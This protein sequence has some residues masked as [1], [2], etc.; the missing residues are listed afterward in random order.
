MRIASMRGMSITLVCALAFL[1]SS[2]LGLGEQSAQGTFCQAP[3]Q[4]GPYP[5]FAPTYRQGDPRERARSVTGRFSLDDLVARLVGG[6]DDP[7]E[8][9]R[10]IHDWEALNISYDFS[11][12]FSGQIP[13]QD[14]GSVLESRKAVCEGY[15]NL[16]KA[17]C[18]RAGVA[19]AVIHSG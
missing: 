12:F 3:E 2:C 9:T 17:M 19:C 18:G 6:V 14:A 7:A 4:A 10:I 5:E 13:P 16:F 8:K 15:S 11:A 1:S